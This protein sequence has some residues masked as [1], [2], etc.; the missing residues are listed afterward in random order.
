MILS[1]E[2]KDIKEIIISEVMVIE[3][4]YVNDKRDSGGATRYGVTEAMAR[5]Y[6]YNGKM[7]DYPKKDAIM[8][9]DLACTFSLTINITRSNK[10]IEIATKKN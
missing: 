7:K 6:G 5:K 8:V 2:L 4:D 9:Y 1:D 10:I 3:G